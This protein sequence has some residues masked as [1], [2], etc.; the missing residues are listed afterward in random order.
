V[1]DVHAV[2]LPRGRLCCTW[3]WIATKSPHVRVK[4][5]QDG[6]SIQVLSVTIAVL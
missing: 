3:P 6:F 5:A 2:D 4:G 1:R